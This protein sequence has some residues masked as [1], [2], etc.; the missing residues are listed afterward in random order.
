MALR[1]QRALLLGA[2]VGA[3][4]AAQVDEYQVKAAFLYNFAKFVEWP[5]RAFNSASAPIGVCILGE[6]PFGRALD[7]AMSGKSVDGH[8]FSIRQVTDAQ[9]AGDC[10]IL[11][12]SSSERKRFHSILSD[13]KAAAG[14][15]TV[16]DT[17]GFAAEGG[18]VNFKLEGDKVRIQI[19][20]DAA[21]QEN[22]RISS[23]LLSLAQ[24]VKQ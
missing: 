6:N 24:I 20:V 8:P 17:E 23:K 13:L 10:Q 21:R 11:F 22:L 1:F 3:A 15:L 4:T 16:G 5:A 2:L 14:V 12:V 9:G 18:V 19:N 7:T